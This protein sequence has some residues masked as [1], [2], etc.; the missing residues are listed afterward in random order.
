MFWGWQCCS[1]FWFCSSGILKEHVARRTTNRTKWTNSMP[2]S[3][4]WFQSIKF[5]SVAKFEVY[6]SCHR[7]HW[8]PEH[9]STKTDYIWDDSHNSWNFPACQAI[10]VQKSNDLRWRSGWTQNIF[11]IRQEALIRKPCSKRSIFIKQFFF[12]LYFSVDPPS[13]GLTCTCPSLCKWLVDAT[14]RWT[15][16]RVGLR[17]VEHGKK[18]WMRHGMYTE[19]LMGKHLQKRIFRKVEEGGKTVLG[20]WVEEVRVR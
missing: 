13:V 5:L 12:Y 2:C 15:P 19:F 9:A 11:F 20:K 6:C 4:P 14:N 17:W 1:T 18:K 16:K 3:L 8:T 7:S 10:T